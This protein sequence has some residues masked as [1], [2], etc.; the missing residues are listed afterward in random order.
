VIA[1]P[2]LLL[3]VTTVMCMVISL[4]PDLMYSLLHLLIGS[5]ALMSLIVL[6]LRPQ[7]TKSDFALYE[8]VYYWGFYVPPAFCSWIT[9]VSVTSLSGQR[10][11]LNLCYI[12]TAFSQVGRIWWINRRARKLLGQRMQKTY[13]RAISLLWALSP[14]PFPLLSKPLMPLSASKQVCYMHVFYL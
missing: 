13:R 5:S 9:T 4:T 11:P 12:F 6:A 8:I 14:L 7:G 2:A 10:L 3:T 1:I